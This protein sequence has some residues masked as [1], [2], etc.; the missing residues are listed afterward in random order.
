MDPSSPLPP[1]SPP[2]PLRRPPGLGKSLL[3]L[4][5]FVGL[6]A[7]VNLAISQF[8]AA[9]GRPVDGALTI[10]VT[11][12]IGWPLILW[13]GLTMAGWR[14]RDC[15]ALKPFAPRILP[16]LAVAS[17][18]LC[19]VL[20]Y[21]SSLIPMPESI[22]AMFR[23]ISQ[24]NPILKF[25]AFVLVAPLAEELFFRGWM[26][27]AFTARYSLRTGVLLTAVVFAAYH[28]NPWQAVIALPLGLLF[29]WLVL[30]TGSLVPGMIG[31]AIVNGSANHLLLPLGRLLGHSKLELET[32]VPWD[33][34]WLGIVLAAAGL[35]VLAWQL[36][37]T[38]PHS[39]PEV[40]SGE[41]GLQ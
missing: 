38:H 24:G 7:G 28:L 26:L 10:L 20:V 18:G 31:H 9:T 17:F 29:A 39:R 3:L 36:R 25:I 11:Q 21:L 30:R 34:L 6:D 19:I 13:A 35:G 37:P 27:R 16:A 12:A 15:Y 40:G 2:Q 23:E 4:F 14:W 32:K 5:I 1:S 8:A 33:M 22:K 41:N